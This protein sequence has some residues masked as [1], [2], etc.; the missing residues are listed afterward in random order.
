MTTLVVTFVLV[1]VLVTGRFI[2]YL[3]SA[4]VGDI[5]ADALFLI[6]AYRLPE[7]FQ[8]ILPLSL[9][10]AILLVL[11]GM[12]VTNEMTV[13]NACGIGRKAVIKALS[14]PVAVTTILIAVL[15]LYIT[16]LGDEEGAK[17]RDAQK[18]RSILELLTPGRFHTRSSNN[19]SRATYAGSVDKEKGVLEN[20][21]LSDFRVDP[22]TKRSEL[23]TV[24]AA[25]GRMVQHEGMNYLELLDGKQYQGQPGEGDFRNVVFEKALVRV[26]EEKVDRTPKVRSWPTAKLVNSENAEAN[27]ELQWRIS[28]ILIV[29]IMA[30]AAIPLARV[31]P[32]QGRFGKIIPAVL[33]Y[34]LYMGVLLVLRSWLADIPVAQRPWYY[35]MVWIHVIAL[36]LVFV[37]YNWSD[38]RRG[39]SARKA[40]I[41]A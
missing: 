34:M 11:G 22:T 16:P 10:I 24:W 35:H 26:G 29:P 38:W 13:M 4:A 39:R 37:F 27:A 7:F 20:V 31:N 19:G 14:L 25:E 9:Y 6:M 3:A 2:K 15:A 33:L 30:L 17:L 12:Y 1:M 28:L 40:R 8:L 36:A 18:D 23:V 5:A 21:F 32:R 41:A